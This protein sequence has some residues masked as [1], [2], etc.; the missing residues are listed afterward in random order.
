MKF[1]YKYGCP[2]AFKIKMTFSWFW[3]PPR[4]ISYAFAASNI[5]IYKLQFILAC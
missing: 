1:S 2:T 3:G 5:I 4:Y